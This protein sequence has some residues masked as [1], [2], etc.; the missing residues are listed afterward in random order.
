ML[1]LFN[2][3]G[4]SLHKDIVNKLNTEHVKSILLQLLQALINLGVIY[5]NNKLNNY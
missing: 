1:V 2:I 5:D 3:K 4:I